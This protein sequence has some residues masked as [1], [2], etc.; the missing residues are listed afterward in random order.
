MLLAHFPLAIVV[1]EIAINLNEEKISI[2]IAFVYFY[3]IYLFLLQLMR[4]CVEKKSELKN[5][6]KI[7]RKPYDKEIEPRIQ[8]I[9]GIGVPFFFFFLL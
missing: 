3:F 7:L 5:S 1:R 8:N 6:G 2:Q 9:N 4:H